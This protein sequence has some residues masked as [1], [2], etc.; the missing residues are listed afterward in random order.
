M[1]LLCD[2]K[3]HPSIKGDGEAIVNQYNFSI[4]KMAYLITVLKT[5]KSPEEKNFLEAE[6]ERVQK[7]V[8]AD[9]E[10]VWR[11]IKKYLIDSKIVNDE[12]EDADTLHLDIKT[13]KVYAI[14]VLDAITLQV[15]FYEDVEKLMKEFSKPEVLKSFKD[16]LLN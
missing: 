15:K 9:G 14:S 4:E 6:I 7:Q 3:D 10:V 12:T 16:K 2:L 1:K 11:K 13:Q 8:T 5:V